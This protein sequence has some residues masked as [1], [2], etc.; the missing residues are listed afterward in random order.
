MWRLR[1]GRELPR[2]LLSALS[3]T[4]IAASLRYAIAPPRSEVRVASVGARG[5]LAAE[6]YALVFARAYLSWSAAEPEASARALA[7]FEGPHLEPGLGLQLPPGG[8][9][10]VVWADVVQEREPEPAEHVYTVA[11]QTT[12]AGVVYLTVG[13]VR[14]REGALALAGY[15]AFV[16]P[17]A[18]APP[19]APGRLHEVAEPALSTVVTRALR[20]Y[21]A[22]ASGDLAA[23][24]TSRA[25]VSMPTLPLA[26]DSLQHLYWATGGGSVLALLAAHDERGTR[27]ELAYELDVARA[28]GRWEISAV[29]MD[30]AA[31]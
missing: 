5:D 14:G 23:D 22:G 4:G 27:Y 18:S 28:Q 6:G 17:P 31:T 24:L 19:P 3:V 12:T 15:P 10:Q 30:P 13:V 1:L 11:A 7:R 21:L 16:G 8:A 25:R 2:Y 26:L 20:N 29:Q 9:Q